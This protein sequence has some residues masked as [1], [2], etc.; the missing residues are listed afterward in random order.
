MRAYA[1]WDY[2][3]YFGWALWL[4]VFLPPLDFIN[5]T[6]WGIVMTG[7]EGTG[8]LVTVAYFASRSRGVHI[9]RALRMRRWFLFWVA[10]TPWF[11]ACLVAA[12]ALRDDFSFAFT[13]AGVAGAL[14]CL[15]VGL[16]SWRSQ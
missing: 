10:W 6:V 5:G 3:A 16:A 2:R 12:A 4:L 11:A 14:P 8:I 1:A 7:A 15:I 9:A 13:A